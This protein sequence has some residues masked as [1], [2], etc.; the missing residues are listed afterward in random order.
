MAI[1]STEKRANVELLYEDG[2]SERKI[3]ARLKM[4]KS[5]VHDIIQLIK[6]TGSSARRISVGP[7]RCTSARTDKI[8][9]RAAVKNPSATSTEILAMLPDNVK[10]SSSTIRRRLISSGLRAYRPVAK[11]R[12][13]AKNIKDRLTFCKAHQHWTSAQWSRVMFSDETLVKQF[14]PHGHGFVRRP[15]NERYN[16]RYTTPSVKQC[17]SL[18]V[19]ASISANG[20]G[21]IQIMKKSES[22][23]AARYLQILENAL[24]TWLNIRGCTIFQHDGAPCHQARVVKSWLQNN[25]I[26]VLHPWPG[27]SPD[28]NPI[29]NCW[30]T[31]KKNVAKRRP[32]SIEALRRDILSVWCTEITPEYCAALVHSMPERIK[33]VLAAKGRHTKY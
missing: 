12:L 6:N 29:E 8:I 4:K 9:R 18:M 24:P 5:T 33:A 1:T 3:A 25:N 31:L 23:N 22:I 16:P 20:R 19:W 28:I 11:P 26:Q 27:C 21:E 10:C 14:A 2:L 32:S 30:V 15:I 17:P 13:S 7:K